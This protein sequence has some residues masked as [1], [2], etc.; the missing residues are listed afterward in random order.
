VEG[1]TFA[2]APEFTL[3]VL[4][5]AAGMAGRAQA[6]TTALMRPAFEFI[7]EER[8]RNGDPPPDPYDQGLHEKL[9]TAITQLK[10]AGFLKRMSRETFLDRLT[11]EGHK[12]LAT[13]GEALARAGLMRMPG[14]LSLGDSQAMSASARAGAKRA[15]MELRNREISRTSELVRKLGKAG[16]HA[17]AG[18][19]SR[20]AAGPAGAPDGLPHFAMHGSEYPE[21]IGKI[22]A[23]ASKMKERG[24]KK[25]ALF[26]VG[27][28][29]RSAFIFFEKL[30]PAVKA[31]DAW[32]VAELMHD[33]G[34]G[35]TVTE[36]RSLRRVDKAFFSRLAAGARPPEE[37]AGPAAASAAAAPR[38]DKLP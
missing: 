8:E 21:A 6:T 2:T 25:W 35:F 37:A 22:R 16:F 36:T 27:P 9:R 18:F 3:A 23:F 10:E 20:A 5:A 15:A 1:A 26:A 29:S 11:P 30:N 13:G 38:R 14:D 28:L 24:C 31:T 33:L 4:R 34:V 32:Q 12:A 7:A 17:L 19:L